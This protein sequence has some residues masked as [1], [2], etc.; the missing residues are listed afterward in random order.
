M[1]ALRFGSLSYPGDVTDADRLQPGRLLGQDPSGWPY[2]VAQVEYQPAV[3]RT[4]VLLQRA[5]AETVQ[6]VVDRL[7]GQVA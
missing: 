1:S 3:D 4:V 5:T 2:E 7:T 6:A